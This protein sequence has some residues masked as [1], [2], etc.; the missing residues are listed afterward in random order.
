[1]GY[2][3]PVTFRMFVGLVF[4]LNLLFANVCVMGTAFAAT[5]VPAEVLSR[6]VPMSFNVVTCTWVKTEDGWQPAADSPCASGHCLKKEKPDTRCVTA[7]MIEMPAAHIPVVSA[8]PI[9]F[10]RPHVVT[11][12]ATESPPPYPGHRSTVLLM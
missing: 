2:T 6:E 5:D 8:Q 10:D 3:P 11:V 1:M 7:N 9:L 4:S 12:T